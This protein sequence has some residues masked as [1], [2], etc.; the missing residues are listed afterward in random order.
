MFIGKTS[1]GQHGYNQ[2]NPL[3]NT[4]LV[5]PSSWPMTNAVNQQSPQ[6]T[7]DFKG[8]GFLGFVP[9][10]PQK[11]AKI[12]SGFWGCSLR[13]LSHV[14]EQEMATQSNGCA[15]QSFQSLFVSF[16]LPFSAQ[17][18]SKYK[19]GN[20]SVYNTLSNA[21]ALAVLW[22]MAFFKSRAQ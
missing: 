10:H 16:P 21:K 22:S 14:A 2:I 4:S 11:K 12:Y 13:L 7:V 15:F 8:E 18:A 6:H 1:L 20:K 5:S 17:G 9:R 19:C 3:R